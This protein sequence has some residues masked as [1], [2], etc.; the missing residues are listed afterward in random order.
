MEGPAVYGKV[1]E[2]TGGE[3]RERKGRAASRTWGLSGGLFRA[4]SCSEVTH[5]KFRSSGMECWEQIEREQYRSEEWG[6]EER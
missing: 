6:K 2:E 5:F 3:G 4:A 1:R